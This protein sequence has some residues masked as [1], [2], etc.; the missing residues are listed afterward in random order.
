MRHPS[1]RLDDPMVDYTPP[2][3]R[4]PSTYG[5][6]P[7]SGVVS[8]AT[9]QAID[10]KGMV[11]GGLLHNWATVVGPGL[12]A[13]T[14]PESLVFPRNQRSGATLTLRVGGAVAV[15][16]QHMLPTLLERVNAYL[17]GRS[18]GRLTIQ[19]VGPAELRPPS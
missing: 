19:T 13:Q 15:E 3:P 5:L 12:A 16:V 1:R 8:R 11:F 6:S 10:R 17:R 14:L 7:V 4:A 9:K 2:P 18:L